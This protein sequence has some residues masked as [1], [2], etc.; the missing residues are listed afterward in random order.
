MDGRVAV[1]GRGVNAVAAGGRI[2]GYGREDDDRRGIAAV[3][4]IE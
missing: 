2:I 4:L 3:A 1:D